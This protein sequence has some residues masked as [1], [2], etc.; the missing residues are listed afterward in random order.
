[1]K[2]CCTGRI[3][4]LNL[5]ELCDLLLR[6]LSACHVCDQP[7]VIGLF[8]GVD[9]LAAI[10][11]NEVVDFRKH[12]HD[13]C[14]RTARDRDSQVINTADSVSQRWSLRGLFHL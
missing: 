3:A 1:M 12:M 7:E 11:S 6:V 14:E 8:P 9:E 13:M 5:T 10:K 4:S 2:S